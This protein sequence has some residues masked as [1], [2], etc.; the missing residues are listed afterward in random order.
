MEFQKKFGVFT[1]IAKIFISIALLWSLISSLALDAAYS[2]LT[3]IQMEY[4]LMALLVI[5]LQFLVAA[6]RQYAMLSLWGVRIGARQSI[7]TLLIGAFF[8]NSVITFIGGDAMRVWRL[9]RLG[10][11]FRRIVS[12]VVTDRIIGFAAIVILVSVLLPYTLEIV[13]DPVSRWSVRILAFGG[14]AGIACYVF[15][16]FFPIEFSRIAYI[17]ALVEFATSS[18]QLIRHPRMGAYSLFT[19]A[20]MHVLNVL[21]VYFLCVGLSLDLKILDAFILVPPVLF[22][23]MLPISIAGWGVREG[24]MAVALGFVFIPPEG[25][26]TASIAFGVIHL[27]IGLIGGPIWFFSRAQE[28]VRQSVGEMPDQ[29][30]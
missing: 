11:G 30:A 4:F 21:G 10:H 7:E 15:V 26:V 29:N 18:R 24:A 3:N 12:A 20:A 16:G 8:S 25:A 5:G 27:A 17:G 28:P 13:T 19:G 23:S 6:Y 1:L 2:G 22:I 14:I 9:L